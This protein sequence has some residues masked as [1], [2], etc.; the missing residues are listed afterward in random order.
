MF[1]LFWLGLNPLW[2]QLKKVMGERFSGRWLALTGTFKSLLSTSIN[3]LADSIQET[4]EENDLWKKWS[5]DE[6]SLAKD[7]LEKVLVVKTVPVDAMRMTSA[8]AEKL[9]SKLNEN[10]T[11]GATRNAARIDDKDWQSILHTYSE[12]LLQYGILVALERIRDGDRQLFGS[13]I[14]CIE[15]NEPYKVNGRDGFFDM[16]KLTSPLDGDISVPKARKLWKRRKLAKYKLTQGHYV[17]SGY[18]STVG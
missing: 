12:A 3:D 7:D 14:V 9:K 5:T 17:D 6:I 15:K 11:L 2:G 13:L 8:I 4:V 1:E 16:V 10:V 18:L